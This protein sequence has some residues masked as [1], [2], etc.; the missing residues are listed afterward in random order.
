MKYLKTFETHSYL[1]TLLDKINDY[2]YDYLT[3]LEINWLKAHAEDKEVETNKIERE[4]G[5]KE[6]V[7]SHNYF[8]FK[9]SE[10]IRNYDTG[11][12][13]YKGVLTIPEYGDFEGEFTHDPKTGEVNLNFDKKINGETIN[14]EDCIEGL[15]NDL[16]AFL[17][18]IIDELE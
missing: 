5:E 9:L 11:L 17:N 8:M 16:F 13:E 6:F 12:D 1:D 14:A 4:M 18:D 3:E 2:G 15:I 10:V 7:S